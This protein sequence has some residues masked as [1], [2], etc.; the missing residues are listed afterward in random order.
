MSIDCMGHIMTNAVRGG[1]IDGL[2]SQLLSFL[3]LWL[4]F[5]QRGAE[6]A[7]K[8]QEQTLHCTPGLV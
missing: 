8:A 3:V 1:L 7:F 4:I 2:A 5:V 6:N